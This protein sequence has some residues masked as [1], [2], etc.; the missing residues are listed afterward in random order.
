MGCIRFDFGSSYN[1]KSRDTA[2]K[3]TEKLNDLLG[4]FNIGEYEFFNEIL[5]NTIGFYVSSPNM[6][7][8]PERRPGK[9]YANIPNFFFRL[10]LDESARNQLQ[11][12]TLILKGDLSIKDDTRN[13]CVYVRDIYLAPQT[14]KHDYEEYYSG[15]ADYQNSKDRFNYSNEEISFDFA[16]KIPL[17]VN[18]VKLDQFLS[19]WRTYLEFE[20]A[21]TIGNIKCHP[22]SGDIRYEPVCEIVDNAVNREKFEVDIIESKNSEKLFVDRNSPKLNGDEQPLFLLSIIIEGKR[23]GDTKDEIKK[24]AV[25][26]ARLGL[27]I[28]GQKENNLLNDLITQLKMTDEERRR[29]GKE[30]REPEGVDMDDSLTPKYDDKTD[31]VIFKFLV[32]EDPKNEIKK[33][34]DNLFLAHIASGDIALYKRGKDT[35]DRIEKGDVKNPYIAGYIVEPEKFENNTDLFNE[36]NVQFALK[37]LNN[38]QKKPLSNALTVT[39]SFFC[40]G[41]PE[42]ERPKPLPNLFIN[43]TKWARKFFYL[44]RRTSR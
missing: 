20:K 43:L 12:N 3:L 34:G 15:S 9:N 41:L 28:I 25:N 7:R 18:K 27:S 8:D 37:D 39:A 33:S 35:L 6:N 36:Q 17:I 44:R 1:D 21:V 22:I 24:S 30:L 29:N 42:P 5:P 4:R 2:N 19:D 10:D 26:F 11:G 23:F 16:Q 14:D 13:S 32:E 31:N 38:S 40:R